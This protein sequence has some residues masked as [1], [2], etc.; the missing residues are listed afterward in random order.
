MSSLFTRTANPILQPGAYPPWTSGAVFNPGAW[1]YEGLVHLLFRAIPS[2]YKISS[3][4]RDPGQHGVSSFRNY[5]TSVGYACSTDAIRFDSRPEPFIKPDSDFDRFGVEDARISKIDDTFLITYTG[6]SQPL[7]GP[8][9]GIRIVLASTTDFQSVQKH[10]VI[11]PDCSDKDAVIFPRRINGQIVMLHRIAPDIQLIR[12]DDLEELYNPP[13]EK[14]RKHMETLDDH[15]MM[16]P[17]NEWEARKIGAGPTPIE[18]SEGWLLIYHGV[19]VQHVYRAG[20]VLLDLDDPSRVIARSSQPVFSPETDFE[21]LGDVNNVVFPQGA[22]VIDDV[23]HV[24]YGAA[25]K[26][27]GHATARLSDVLLYLKREAISV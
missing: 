24:Y 25:D 11:G 19:D 20:L 15:V 13:K 22:V 17:E 18:T 8:L 7:E 5:V 27:I 16:R 4:A 26:V 14:W 23:L 6:L 12:F 2:G 3:D 10:G 1:Y 21:L 9:N